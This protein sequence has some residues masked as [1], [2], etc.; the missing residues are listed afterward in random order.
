MPEKPG[1]GEG[2]TEET[3]EPEPTETLADAVDIVAVNMEPV[4][5]RFAFLDQREKTLRAEVYDAMAE[6]DYE[7]ALVATMKLCKVGA[8]VNGMQIVLGRKKW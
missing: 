7:G 2:E 4:N 6:Q 1:N 5:R 3:P 8:D